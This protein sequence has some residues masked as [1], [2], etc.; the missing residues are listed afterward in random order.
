MSHYW[1]GWAAR[2]PVRDLYI[3]A[4]APPVRASSSAP[5][6]PSEA[7]STTL[8]GGDRFIC[9]AGGQVPWSR[10]AGRDRDKSSPFF[11]AV[12]STSYFRRPLSFFAASFRILHGP[13]PRPSSRPS[14]PVPSTAR[15]RRPTPPHHL[16]ARSPL[17]FAVT[18]VTT[19]GGPRPPGFFPSQSFQPSFLP[20]F[21][22]V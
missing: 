12:I 5:S 15:P 8:R 11:P 19:W 20:L 16:P 13:R 6:T 1:L 18:P 10:R 17:S 4:V 3:V 21:P 14:V 2:S 22:P 7:P 9:L